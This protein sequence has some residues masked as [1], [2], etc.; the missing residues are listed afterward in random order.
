M[1]TNNNIFQ[2][3]NNDKPFIYSNINQANKEPNIK[4][5]NHLNPGNITFNS[6]GISNKNIVPELTSEIN[7]IQNNKIEDQYAFKCVIIG[8]GGVGK[9]TFINRSNNMKFERDYYA[10]I[11]CTEHYIS[12]DTSIGKILFNVF[13]TAGQEKLAG[14]R[15]G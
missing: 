1:T 11:G 13:D 15:D 8:D 9:T 12:F 10:T 7:A 2:I 4:T 6:I 14:L 3:I 5:T